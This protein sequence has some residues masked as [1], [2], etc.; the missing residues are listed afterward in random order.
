MGM[1]KDKDE[2]DVKDSDIEDIVS[3]SALFKFSN[4]QKTS[5]PA[6][7]TDKVSSFTFAAFL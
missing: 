6:T 2:P 4:Q 3:K 7:P 1:F 5:R